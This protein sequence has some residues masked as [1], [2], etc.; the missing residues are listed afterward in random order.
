MGF[1]FKSDK[2]DRLVAIFDI[3]SGSVGGAI[4][5]IP[6][7]NKNIPSIIKSARTEIVF[8]NELNFDLFLND[9]LVALDTTANK[10]YQGKVGAPEEVYCVV[11]S[12][13]YLSETRTIKMSRDQPFVFTERFGYDL[14]K[15][16]L[17]LVTELYKNKYSKLDSIP[18][19]IEHN[20]INVM[21]N[22]YAVSDPLGKSAQTVEM[23]MIISLAPAMCLEN[24][25]QSISKTYHSIPISF[26]SFSVN[27]Y[28]AVRDRYLHLDS[29]LLLDIS[30]E[31]TDVSIV[32]KGVLKSTLSF[33]FGKKTFLKYLC[34][35]LNIDLRDAQELFHLHISG[36]ISP[37]F[38]DKLIPIFKT[39]EDLWSSSFHE[40]INT[41]PHTFIVPKTIFLTIDNDIK[42]YFINIIR[43]QDCVVSMASETKFNVVTLDGPEFLNMCSVKDGLCDPFLMIEAIAI[44]RKTGK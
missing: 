12:P 29:Y 2:K 9:M 13:W 21:L 36:M 30:G 42:D 39:V 34:K 24:I 26:S 38:G 1:L 20:I 32:S 22:G 3:G 11:S 35:E 6:Y 27:S 43:N 5:R 23:N 40:C 7:D 19:V 31:L 44:M 33:P 41:L 28:L 14:F 16:E 25:R 15:K 4:A 17:S 18:E 37:K 8:Q 10:L